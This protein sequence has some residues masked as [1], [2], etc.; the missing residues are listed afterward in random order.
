MLSGIYVAQVDGTWRL[1]DQDGVELGVEGGWKVV[2]SP[3][4]EVGT[5]VLVTL[6]GQATPKP[7]QYLGWRQ[8][9]LNDPNV[10]GSVA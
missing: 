1:W 8:V 10:G 2:G 7:V 9:E 3:W 6:Q 5:M 4:P